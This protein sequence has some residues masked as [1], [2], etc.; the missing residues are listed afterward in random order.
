MKILV[1]GG[2]GAVGSQTVL[3][4][5]DRGVQVRVMTRN[6]EKQA[7]LPAGVEGVIADLGD[8]PSLPK[9]LE[10]IESVVLIVPV[11]PDETAHGLFAVKAAKKAGVKKI[12]YLSVVMPPEAVRIPHFASKVPVENAIRESGMAYTILR[13]NNFFQNDVGLKDAIVKYGVYPQP[14]GSIGLNRVDI[15]DIAEAAVNSLFDA[16]HDGKTYDI[17]G[18]DTLTGRDTAKIY[19]RLL[20]SEVN[21]GGDDLDA[22][23]KQVESFLPGWMVLDLRIMYEVFQKYG[24]IA[25]ES[26]LDALQ[27]VLRHRP[28]SFEAFAAEN[29]PLWKKQSV[30]A[31]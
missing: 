18:P 23:T 2:T 1:I 5:L 4:L 7:M 13:P 14:I 26:D 11:H 31:K 25:K 30:P 29:V 20:G 17:H 8:P 27:R 12:V 3:R 16:G 19:S 6:A 22:W 28:R 21:Y 10:G 15:R 24:M 9:A